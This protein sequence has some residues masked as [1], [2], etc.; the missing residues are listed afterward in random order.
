MFTGTNYQKYNEM[1][2]IYQP[3][4]YT[5]VY[6]NVDPGVLPFRTGTEFLE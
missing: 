2:S 3:P 5:H 1:S 6:I 4:L